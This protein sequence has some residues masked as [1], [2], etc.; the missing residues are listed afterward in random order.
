M[1]RFVIPAYN[2]RENIP[3]LLADLGP[4]ARELGARVIF[5]DDG[6]TDGTAEAIEAHSDSVHLAIVR[7]DVNRGLG[8][9]INS[10]LRAAL[11]E[12]QD[13]DAIVTLEADN[14]SDLSDLPRMLERFHEGA[15]IVLASVYAPGGRIVGVA[16]WRL[17]ASKSVS[18][19]FRY[20]GGLRDIHTLSSL[21]RV[22]RAGTLRRA[23]ETYGYLLVREP[24]FA[25]NVEL[26]LK[27]YNAGASVAE[28]PT[29]NDWSRRLGTSKMSLRPTILAYGRL[30]AAH[31]VG[32]IQPPPISPLGSEHLAARTEQRPVAQLHAV[33]EKR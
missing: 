12:S 22:Y 2:E 15:D 13:G 24:G 11:G 3:N 19:V 1:I 8:T 30:M 9:A 26:L 4:V 20:T 17:A 29:V 7:H 16:P 23:S 5:V 10:G 21:Y 25:A 6:S 28:V 14:T 32:R 31:L 27:L 33:A 18:N